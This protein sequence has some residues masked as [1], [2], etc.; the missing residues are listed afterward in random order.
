[1]APPPPGAGRGGDSPRQ[2]GGPGRPLREKTNKE[3]TREKEKK[4]EEKGKKRKKKE[5]KRKKS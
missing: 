5:K 3:K 4:K 1:M 2:F